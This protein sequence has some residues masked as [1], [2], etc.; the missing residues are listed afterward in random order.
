MLVLFQGLYDVTN[1]FVFDVSFT[2]SGHEEGQEDG[3]GGGGG[4]VLL[5]IHLI[6]VHKCYKLPHFNV[7]IALYCI[8]PPPPPPPPVVF[9]PCT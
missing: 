2:E 4:G 7:Y 1:P 3:G 5:N 6:N 8:S 9:I